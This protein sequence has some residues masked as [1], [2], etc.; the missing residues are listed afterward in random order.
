MF[1]NSC[2]KGATDT[3]L[4]SDPSNLSPSNLPG[5]SSSS[6][7]PGPSTSYG[8]YRSTDTT[9]DADEVQQIRRLFSADTLR[10]FDEHSSAIDS[11][12][13]IAANDT[14]TTNPTNILSESSDAENDDNNDFFSNPLPSLV[15]DSIDPRNN[16]E[17]NA[18]QSISAD[19]LFAPEESS[20]SEQ[21]FQFSRLTIS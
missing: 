17:T 11:V 6:D 16:Y 15:M 12:G 4:H 20:N 9:D 1:N 19:Q 14:D 7:L 8:E 5:P 21:Q 10:I 13:R 3:T 2:R 18:D